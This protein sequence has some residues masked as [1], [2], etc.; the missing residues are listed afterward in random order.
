[1]GPPLRLR[2]GVSSGVYTDISMYIHAYIHTYVSKPW[3]F[4]YKLPERTWN[5]PRGPYIDC[6][7]FDVV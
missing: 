2:S 7:G 4:Q 1:M 5:F 3:E 6:S